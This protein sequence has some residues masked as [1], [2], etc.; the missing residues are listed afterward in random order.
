MRSKHQNLRPNKLRKEPQ[1]LSLLILHH[2]NAF[3]A[4]DKQPKV[5]GNENTNFSHADMDK[6]IH[7]CLNKHYC[8]TLLL[9]VAKYRLPTVNLITQCSGHYQ[10]RT[11]TVTTIYGVNCIDIGNSVH[12]KFLN[13]TG[14]NRDTFGNGSLYLTV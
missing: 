14:V 7:C 10:A 3:M 5:E 8:F 11:R 13:K 12:N 9:P 6:E 4:W 1:L 2:A